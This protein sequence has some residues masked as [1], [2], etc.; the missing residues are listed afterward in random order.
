MVVEGLWLLHLEWLR[1]EFAFSVFV[2]CR[3]EERLSRRIERD[4]LTR[5]RTMESVRE[6]FFSHVKPMH[7]LFVE[8]QRLWATRCV[9][10]P[11]SETEYAE[12]L[13]ACRG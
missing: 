11:Q 6:Q 4:V 7:E 1:K 8:P 2:D 9:D 3:E 10:S 13:A 12:L 5:G